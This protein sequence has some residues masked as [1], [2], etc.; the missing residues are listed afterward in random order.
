MSEQNAAQ[1]SSG[2]RRSPP[3]WMNATLSL[4]LRSPLHGLMSDKLML[5]SFTGRKSGKKFTTPVTYTR[6]ND[7]TVA[8]FSNGNWW[9]NLEGGA[10]VTVLIAGRTYTAQAEPTRDVATVERETR[11]Y[12]KK[13]GLKNARFIGL[14]IDTTREPTDAEYLAIARQ[15]VIV[16]VR[17]NQHS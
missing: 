13:N 4:L 14:D 17:L 9:K 8:F 1:V 6:I 16:Y 3:P 5:I 12:L 7:T 15:R 11:A 2:P 10:P